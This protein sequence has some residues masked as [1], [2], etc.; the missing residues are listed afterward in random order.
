MPKEPLFKRIGRLKILGASIVGAAVLFVG[1]IVFWGG[2]NTAMEATNQMEFCISCHEMKDNVY[3]EYKETIHFTNRTGVQ[4][5]CPDCHVPDPWIHKMIRKV[6]ASREL[7]HW[8]WGDVDTPE[9]FDAKRLELAKR[10]WAS[11]ESNDSRECRNC[12]S[13]TSMDTEKQKTRASRMHERAQ[14]DGQTCIDC[15]KG[16]AHKPVHQLLEDEDAPASA[17]VTPAV[18]TPATPPPAV[19]EAAAT[20]TPAS[21]PAPAAAPAPA[22]ETPA[23]APTAAPAA[24]GGG[25]ASGI[26]WAAAPETK[27][28]LFY[29][30]TTS[31]EWIQQGSDHGGARAFKAG[32]NCSFCHE[33][34]QADM[35]A[36]MVSGAKAEP[37]PI[38][39][40]PAF[41]PLTVKAAFDAD[42][43]YMRF[44]WPETPHSPIPFAEGGMMDPEN[45]VKL[46]V[47]LDAG[48]V[49]FAGQS[50]CW[51]SC[52]HD[53]RTMPD[54]PA[55]ASAVAGRLDVSHG[56]TKYLPATRSEIEIRGADGKP[57]GGWD[58]LK[59]E[60]E[61]AAML[62]QGVFLDLWRY[63]GGTGEAENSYVLAERVITDANGLSFEGGLEGGVW[64]VTMTRK[65]NTG[66]PGDVVLEPGKTYTLG[67]ALH[68]DHTNG[69]FH[70][71]SIDYRLALGAEGAEI[72]AIQK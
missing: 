59:D 55:D 12:H 69:R 13:F 42:A 37:T 26:D 61:I 27:V 47:M 34:E 71:V 33:G 44:S 9:K 14:Q 41:V 5:T 16:I 29:P 25:S 38:P 11:M 45:P 35:G 1:G 64:T 18:A 28:T 50:A 24:S 17:A 19:Q 49:E 31:F 21:T 4:A 67:F 15:H 23:A 58:K 3:A 2:F 10:V 7:W 51:S 39:G 66:N 63:K 40:K 6:Q 20:S 54:A 22:A 68:D 48:N 72:T 36:K 8:A 43:L 70:H 57:R 30:G 60:R 56:V 46:A 65:L 62:D 52:H 53:A 32:D